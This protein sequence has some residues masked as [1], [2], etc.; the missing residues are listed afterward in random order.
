[1]AI[2]GVS[3]AYPSIPEYFAIKQSESCSV[4]VLAVVL[5]LVL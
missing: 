4:I 5:V 3:P 1:M 2:N